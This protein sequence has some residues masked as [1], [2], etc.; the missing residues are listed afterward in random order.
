[1]RFIDM[2]CLCAGQRN[3]ITHVNLMGDGEIIRR[4]KKPFIKSEW[5][6]Q[7]KCTVIQ[8]VY[9]DANKLSRWSVKQSLT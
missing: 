3:A 8:C 7:M 9:N 6:K 4:K 1:M 5:L 2:K